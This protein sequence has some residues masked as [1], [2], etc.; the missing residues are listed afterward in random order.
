MRKKVLIYALLPAIGFSFFVA[1]AAFAHGNWGW[2][3]MSTNIDP[4][5]IATRQEQMFAN[6][7]Q[8][9]GI[10]VAELKEGWAQGKTMAQIAEDKGITNEQLKEKIKNAMTEQMK[11]YLKTLVDKGVITQAQADKRLAYLSSQPTGKK[12][13]RGFG[14]HGLVMGAKAQ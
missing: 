3:G 10:S 1:N 5:E 2:F 4:D 7:A 13:G 6:E 14:W 9:L 12:M 11:T 8:I